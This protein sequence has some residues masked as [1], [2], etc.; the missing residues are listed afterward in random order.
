MARK[1]VGARIARALLLAAA[2]FVVVTALAVL[3]LRWVDPWTSAVMLES[4]LEARQEGLKSYRVRYR[5]IDASRMSPA[6]ARA[7]VAAEDQLFA[8][9]SGF[10]FEAIRKAAEHNARSKR[11]RG[12]STISQQVAKNLFLWRGRSW[13]RKGFEVWFTVLI[14]A[15]WPKERILEVYLNIA[16]FGRGVYGVEA[17]ARTFWGK[18]A[19]RLTRAE[20]ATLAAVLPNPRRLRATA[21]SPYV[22]RRRDWILRQMSY[23]ET[24]AATDGVPRVR[25]AR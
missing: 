10:D 20:A 19:S 9:H 14:E 24:P 1:G 8:E 2:A 11:V 17:A 3:A 22:Q 4:R 7:V 12:A 23:L 18:S 6:C 21:P 13:V 15:L 16:E 25:E 5:W